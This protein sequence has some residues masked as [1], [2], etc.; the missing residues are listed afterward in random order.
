MFIKRS[1][2][3]LAMIKWSKKG[4][5]IGAIISTV[6][7]LFYKFFHFQWL[8][9]PTLPISLIGIALA[10]YLGFKNNASYDR[11]WEARKVWG[12]IVNYSRS[13]GGMTISYVANGEAGETTSAEELNACKSKLIKT[14]L[15]WLAALR[16]QLITKR[17]W[18]HNADAYYARMH[19]TLFEK[20]N[21]GSMEDEVGHF[22]SEDEFSII[23]TKSNWATQILALQS[24]NIRKLKFQNIINENSQVSMV[25]MV[26]KLYDEQGKC[27][28]IKNFPFPRQYAT[29]TLYFIC[30]FALIMPCGLIKEMK[31]FGENYVW[32]TI[33][34]GTI[35][36]WVFVVM[37]MIGDYSE[38]PFEGS[39]NDTPIFNI[40]RN[41]EIDLLEMIGEKDI[42]KPIT[43][44]DGFLI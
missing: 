35:I 10:F 41:I 38:N 8:A 22:L 19:Q 20:E 26:G 43:D 27:E 7:V 36:T 25:E 2:S 24:E 15:A 3:F 37:E 12:A 44:H 29:V 23:K 42:P 5:V 34:L 31:A 28:R 32:L 39:Y 33:P 17:K 13:F 11:L 9:L 16:F 14:H 1:Y 40:S 4:F 30:L 18:E 6:I 21:I